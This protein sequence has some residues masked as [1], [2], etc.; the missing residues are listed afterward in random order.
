MNIIQPACFALVILT[1]VSGLAAAEPP[2]HP[3]ATWGLRYA[4]RLLTPA[5]LVSIARE[6]LRGSIADVKQDVRDLRA[7]EPEALIKA[8]VTGARLAGVDGGT[9]ALTRF[10]WHVIKSDPLAPKPRLNE[11]IPAQFEAAPD[12]SFRCAV[13]ATARHA[14]TGTNV[15]DALRG[16]FKSQALDLVPAT[17]RSIRHVVTRSFSPTHAT[18]DDAAISNS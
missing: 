13:K 12:R 14:I 4:P 5:G 16:D 9:I 6:E 2:P 11:A 3:T 18:V 7:G 15:G 17:L 1:A 8:G 10:T